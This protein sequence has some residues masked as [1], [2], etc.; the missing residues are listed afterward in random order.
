MVLTLYWFKLDFNGKFNKKRSK[1]DAGTSLGDILSPLQLLCSPSKY[2]DLP[3]PFCRKILLVLDYSLELF[4]I[5][6]QNMLSS[7]FLCSL[8]F[9]DGPL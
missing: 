9:F 1:R 8:F 7:P 6:A 3:N 5:M 4:S 2:L